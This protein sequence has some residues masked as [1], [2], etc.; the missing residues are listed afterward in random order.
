MMVAPLRGTLGDYPVLF[1]IHREF[2][3]TWPRRRSRRGGFIFRGVRRRG[4]V[5]RDLDCE[6][7]MHRTDILD[8]EEFNYAL[9]ARWYIPPKGYSL[10]LPWDKETRAEIHRMNI[11]RELLEAQYE[12]VPT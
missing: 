3:H 10:A 5:R 4:M 1:A 11:E 2:N 6:C 9:V 8:T 7:G 12:E